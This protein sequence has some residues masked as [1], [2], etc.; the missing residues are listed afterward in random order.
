M[1][2][3]LLFQLS[4]QTVPVRIVIPTRISTLDDFRDGRRAHTAESLSGRGDGLIGQ[5]PHQVDGHHAGFVSV[6]SHLAK[7]R[8]RDM[9][10]TPYL[11]DDLRCGGTPGKSFP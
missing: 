2:R 9:K 11:L 8:R 10:V 5:T 3:P 6:A 1:A 7:D 4:E